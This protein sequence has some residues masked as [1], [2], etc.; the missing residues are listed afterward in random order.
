[1]RSMYGRQLCLGTPPPPPIFFLLFSLI[2]LSA[3]QLDKEL[4]PPLL[5]IA[6]HQEEVNIRRR[7]KR[8]S[9]I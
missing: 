4:F 9:F 6:S 7:R 5:R 8:S 1:M 3:L 2:S